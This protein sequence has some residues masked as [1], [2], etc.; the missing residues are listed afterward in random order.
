MTPNS[1]FKAN[2]EGMVWRGSG[3]AKYIPIH[4]GN[5]KIKIISTIHIVCHDHAISVHSLQTHISLIFK[6]RN[7]NNVPTKGG[8]MT[9]EISPISTTSA[10]EVGPSIRY[11]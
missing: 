9:Y 8:Y 6:T 4:G 10:Q 11:R 7:M 1:L 5:N 3:K 2:L